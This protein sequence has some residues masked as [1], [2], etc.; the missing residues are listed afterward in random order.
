MRKPMLTNLIGEQVGGRGIERDEVGKS[1][2]EMPCSRNGSSWAWEFTM[3]INRLHAST[4]LKLCIAK[5]S[6]ESPM[7]GIPDPINKTIT[8]PGNDKKTADAAFTQLK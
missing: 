1:K 3:K 6:H 8:A 7:R 2:W 4:R 5:H